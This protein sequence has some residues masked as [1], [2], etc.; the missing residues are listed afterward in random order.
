MKSKKFR[1]LA[2][3]S[4]SVFAFAIIISI[5]IFARRCNPADDGN[6]GNAVPA[7]MPVTYEKLNRGLVVTR[8]GNKGNT[9]YV[10]W[11]FLVGDSDSTTFDVYRKSG[12]Q[13]VKLNEEP[14]ADS[15]FYVDEGIDKTKEYT[16]HVVA[17]ADGVQEKSEEYT[18]K[19]DTVTGCFFTVPI[20]EGIKIKNVWVGDLNGD[21]AYDFVLD[22]VTDNETVDDSDEDEVQSRFIDGDAGQQSIEAYLNDGTFLWSIDFGKNSTYKYN[23]EPSATTISVGHWD[24][25][26]VYDLDGDDKAEVYIRI[27]NGVTFGDGT[28]FEYDDDKTWVGPNGST[29]DWHQWIARIDGMTGTLVDKVPIPDD[30]IEHGCMAAQ[31]GVG[32]LNGENPSLVAVMKNRT[33]DKYHTFNMMICAFSVKNGALTMDWKWKAHDEGVDLP[34]GHHFRI[35]DVDFDGKDEILEIGFC[36]NGDGTLRYTLAPYGVNHGDR[37]Y[38]GRFNKEDDFMSG[39]GITQLNEEKL[40]EYCYN[41][42]TG[43]MLWRH[44]GES[45]IDVGRGCAADID[46]TKDGVEVWSFSGIYNA[47]TDTLLSEKGQTM[48]PDINIQWDGDLL[49]ESCHCNNYSV[50]VEQWDYET[51]SVSR[52][53]SLYSIYNR[54]VGHYPS[55]D[56]T[57]KYPLFVGDIVGDWREE[58]IV[59]DYVD[60]C[61]VIFTS[62]H[63]TEYRIPTLAQDST[64]RAWMTTKGYKQGST[65][66]FYF[67]ADMDI[68][69]T[70]QN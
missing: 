6:G 51:K 18:L 38:V 63:E 15:T 61:L 44:Y 36:L 31:F 29:Y 57:G 52:V 24:G 60:N 19:A 64:Y 39:Y 22:R 68:K 53:D 37:F 62:Q 49:Y 55:A 4:A 56:T 69:K 50:Y 7:S 40:W 26:S 58:V 34:E 67:G 2:I 3:I 65:T 27:A 14:I 5:V 20:K 17:N 9:A 47:K 59:P 8:G 10:S 16:Y 41:A 32:F 66:S 42:S 45:E 35:C 13:T 70:F 12:G 23:I 46:P 43:E 48:W 30:Y 21:G 33:D 11:R 28:T 25:V 54:N 1:I